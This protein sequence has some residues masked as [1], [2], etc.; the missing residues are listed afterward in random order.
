MSRLEVRPGF[1]ALCSLTCFFIPAETFWPFVL[2]SAA[3]ELGH[4][5]ALYVCRV[6]V[7]GICLG[8]CGAVIRTGT[9]RPAAE[10]ACALSGPAVNL[11]AFRVLRQICPGAAVISLALGVCN[12]VPLW[13]LDGG[14]ALRAILMLFLS[15]PAALRVQ[16][17]T[18]ALVLIAMGIGALA[19]CRYFGA[20]PAL[21]Y[22]GLLLL[23]GR[24]F[25]LPSGAPPDIMKQKSFAA[26]GR[27]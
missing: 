6:P 18:D 3:H 10:A 12:L 26:R 7:A 22:A 19:L 24:I 5:A 15:A 27:I 13:P 11:L 14:R 4:L 23:K 8:A 1:I 20:L 16:A 17:V 21:L 9:M 25:L 2:L